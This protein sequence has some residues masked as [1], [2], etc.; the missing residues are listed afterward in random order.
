M[1]RGTEKR[2][3]GDG[4]KIPLGSMEHG[5]ELTQPEDRDPNPKASNRGQVKDSP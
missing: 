5:L 2:Q 1:E 4:S 3:I